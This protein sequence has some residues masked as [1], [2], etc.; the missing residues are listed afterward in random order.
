MAAYL[1]AKASAQTAKNTLYYVQAVDVPSPR[2]TKPEFY[3]EMLAQP[4]V[5]HTGKLP[6]LLLFHIGMRMKVAQNICPPWVVQDTSVTVIELLLNPRERHHDAS[7]CEILLEYVPTLIVKLDDC[8]EEFLPQTPCNYHGAFTD[9]CPDCRRH[10]GMFMIRPT[11]RIWYFLSKNEPGFKRT[12]TRIS[13]A[14]M[15]YKA[16]SLYSLQGTTALPGL[17]AD[18]TM[19]QRLGDGMKWLVVYV[20]LS[21]VPSLAHLR[22]VGLTEKVRAIIEKGPPAWL[23]DATDKLIEEKHL[24]TKAA[25]VQAREAMGW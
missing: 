5:N 19:P 23:V 9:G 14:V 13:L 10:P 16:C 22:S 3:R 2:I 21:R 8:N 24:R 15:P 17:I 18:F 1:Q 12:V 11:S 4:N 6:G 25:C 20:L 7:S